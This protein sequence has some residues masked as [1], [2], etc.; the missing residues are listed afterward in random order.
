M[1][2]GIRIRKLSLQVKERLNSLKRRKRSNSTNES[3]NIA[4]IEIIHPHF[5]ETQPIRKSAPGE[6]RHN[7]RYDYKTWDSPSLPANNEGDSLEEHLPSTFPVLLD[8]R[9]FSRDEWQKRA[10]TAV[11]GSYRSRNGKARQSAAGDD[12]N[13][14]RFSDFAAQNS[15]QQT[16]P[17]DDRHSVSLDIEQPSAA[18]PPLVSFPRLSS[19]DYN[20]PASSHEPSVIRRSPSESSSTSSGISIISGGVSAL[21]ELLFATNSRIETELRNMVRQ[22]IADNDRVHG[23]MNRVERIIDQAY[24]EFVVAALSVIDAENGYLSKS[25]LQIIDEYC[26]ARSSLGRL[27]SGFTSDN[28]EDTAEHNRLL[29]ELRQQDISQIKYSKE[30]MHLYAAIGLSKYV[31]SQVLLS[32]GIENDLV[33]KLGEAVEELD[34]T[35]GQL[36]I[37]EGLESQYVQSESTDVLALCEKAVEIQARIERLKRET[38]EAAHIRHTFETVLLEIQGL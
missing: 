9:R 18:P 10:D 16:P 17:V 37:L 20:K 8:D 38:Q 4:D 11:F 1:T 13:K 33:D 6:F 2:P 31:S 3:L 30:Q 28:G 25:V 34:K 7:P 29:H 23:F 26:N 35:N 14:M 32:T 5:D 15:G 12:A 27:D 36:D 21:N 24:R 19:S 22:C